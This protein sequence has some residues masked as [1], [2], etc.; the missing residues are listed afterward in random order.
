MRLTCFHCGKP[1]STELPD[2]A[3]VRAIV[4]CPECAAP[5]IAYLHPLV[6]KK[7]KA[8]QAA[9]RAGRA[10]PVTAAAPPAKPGEQR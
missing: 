2:D 1:V 7:W 3:V 4:E 10:M 9:D 6:E 5:E 8:C